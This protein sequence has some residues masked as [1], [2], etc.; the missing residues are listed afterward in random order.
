MAAVYSLGSRHKVAPLPCVPLSLRYPLPLQQP[1]SPLPERLKQDDISPYHDDVSVSIVEIATERALYGLRKVEMYLEQKAERF[2]QEH[3]S[4]TD[5]NTY[6][7]MV[8]TAEDLEIL[9]VTESIKLAALF[10][11][12]FPARVGIVEE[13]LQEAVRAS[14]FQSEADFDRRVREAVA[15]IYDRVVETVP[16]FKDEWLT[17]EGA[18]HLELSPITNT[19]PVPKEA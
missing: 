6:M 19:S 16:E 12:N 17:I 7:G 10:A 15:Y 13:T 18:W 4:S 1:P 9:Y 3:L 2:V 8:G 11:F 5:W 14:G